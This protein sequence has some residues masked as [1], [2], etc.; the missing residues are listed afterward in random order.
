MARLRNCYAPG[1]NKVA[2]GYMKKNGVTHYLYWI[3]D[4]KISK[5]GEGKNCLLCSQEM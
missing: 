1:I 5:K 4:L 3:K 2:H